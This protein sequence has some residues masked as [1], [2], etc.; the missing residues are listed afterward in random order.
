MQEGKSRR[1]VKLLAASFL[2]TEEWSLIGSS[3]IIRDVGF[4]GVIEFNNNGERSL[5]GILYGTVFFGKIAALEAQMT[6]KEE[7]L[8]VAAVVEIK[9]GQLFDTVETSPGERPLLTD[10]IQDSGDLIAGVNATFKSR[11]LQGYVLKVLW[12]PEFSITDSL[13]LQE[14]SFSVEQDR[15]KVKTATEMKLTGKLIID[16]DT[17]MVIS[18]VSLSDN[19]AIDLS[20]GAIAPAKLAKSLVNGGLDGSSSSSKA[21]LPAQTGFSDWDDEKKSGVQTSGTV[22]F[23]KGLKFQSASLRA[24]LTSQKDPWD[25]IDGCIRLSGFVL[26]LQIKIDDNKKHISVALTAEFFLTTHRKKNNWPEKASELSISVE[27]SKLT[28]SFIPGSDYSL[29]DLLYCLTAGFI[30][31]PAA[32]DLPAFPLIELVLDWKSQD[33]SLTA[34]FDEKEKKWKAPFFGELIYIKEPSLAGIIKRQGKPPV[35]VSIKGK[36]G[37]VTLSFLYLFGND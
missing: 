32:F 17:L 30:D 8:T 33:A 21:E 34:F 5:S 7:V 29:G 9:L 36:L 22:V 18:A 13:V 20:L 37:Y 14:A 4:K 35:R 28:V 6:Y 26:S 27:K 25:L 12:T 23:V 11:K 16:K 19:L 2:T 3:L 24:F 1:K 10:Q 31:L 15:T